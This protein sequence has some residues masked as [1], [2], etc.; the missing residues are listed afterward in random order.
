MIPDNGIVSKPTRYSVNQAV[1]KLRGLLR[2]QSII[3]IASP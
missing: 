1:E 2:E 3:G